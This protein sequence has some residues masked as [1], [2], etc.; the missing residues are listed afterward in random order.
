MALC[1]RERDEKVELLQPLF[2]PIR[3]LYIFEDQEMLILPVLS[4][5][6]V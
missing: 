3:N 4:V 1:V 2:D 6:W 5:Y